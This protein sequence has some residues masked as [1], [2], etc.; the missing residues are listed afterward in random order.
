VKVDDLSLRVLSIDTRL[1]YGLLKKCQV[2]VLSF[3]FIHLQQ[4][5]TFQE[6]RFLRN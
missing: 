1:F 4:I 5:K 3:G 6:I 2:T